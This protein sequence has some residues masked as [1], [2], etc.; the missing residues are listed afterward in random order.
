MEL[1]S[2]S[3]TNW[4]TQYALK[5]KKLGVK[6]IYPDGT[7][8][9]IHINR[10]GGDTY[11]HGN[12]HFDGASDWDW[13]TGGGGSDVD[14]TPI[15]ER[16]TAVEEGMTSVE[17]GKLSRTAS[18][19]EG[20]LSDL[21]FAVG[22]RLQLHGNDSRLYVKD[23]DDAIKTR[24]YGNGLVELTNEL[25]IDRESGQAFVVKKAGVATGRIYSDGS[26]ESYKEVSD[27]SKGSTLVTKD[28]LDSVVQKHRPPGLPFR[29]SNIDSIGAGAF[30]YTDAGGNKRMRINKTDADGILWM[31]NSPEQDTNTR[32]DYS[33]AY[34]IRWWDESSKTWK[35]K[36]TG[37]I[38]RIDWHA[39]DIYCY[40]PLHYGKD[41]V[42][43][44]NNYKYWITIGGII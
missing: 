41:G 2:N 36:M 30:H 21:H 18:Q 26:F 4:A 13:D 44:S 7:H 37:F 15:E 31:D 29:F 17:E 39:N 34:S 25:R 42:S 43:F 8:G 1:E 5:L 6:F 24:L 16:L 27:S 12:V 9:E 40:I 20:M 14:L 23:D 22:K 28:Y 38:T 32:D 3:M 11:L 33:T 35:I 19:E 10:E